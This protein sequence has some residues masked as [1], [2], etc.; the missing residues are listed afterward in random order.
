MRTGVLKV[1]YELLK[2]KLGLPDDSKVICVWE[3]DRMM[4]EM[5][6]VRIIIDSPN[7]SEVLEGCI[8]PV[9]TLEQLG[10]WDAG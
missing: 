10:G 9:I 8:P 2:Q 1:S 6:V 5:E 3:G 7:L 4:G